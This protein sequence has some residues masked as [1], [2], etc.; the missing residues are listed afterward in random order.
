VPVIIVNIFEE[1]IPHILP[2]HT[3]L[4]T[5]FKNRFPELT[6]QQPEWTRNK[7][8]VTISEKEIN[9]HVKAKKPLTPLP[10]D[11]SLKIKSK[12]L[13]VPEIWIHEKNCIVHS[14][15]PRCYCWH[16]K[17]FSTMA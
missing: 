14:R 9:P 4:E 1:I 5:N 16:E 2:Y 3:N 7:S 10:G 13:S 15:P 17:T 8:A 6:L 12:D 11:K